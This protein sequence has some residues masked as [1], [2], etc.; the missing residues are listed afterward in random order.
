ME[1]SWIPR[2]TKSN[3]ILSKQE[4][5]RDIDTRLLDLV[6]KSSV[7]RKKRGLSNEERKLTPDNIFALQ[8][9]KRS[10]HDLRS[11]SELTGWSD[12]VI[13]KYTKE[14]PQVSL[15]NAQPPQNIPAVSESSANGSL[16]LPDYTPTSTGSLE[17]TQTTRVFSG[18]LQVTR[19]NPGFVSFRVPRNVTNPILNLTATGSTFEVQLLTTQQWAHF[20]PSRPPMKLWEARWADHDRFYQSP[21]VSSITTELKLPYVDVWCLV[22]QNPVGSTDENS[23][24]LDVSLTTTKQTNPR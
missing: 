13:S 5:S 1:R 4:R 22:F 23:I 19:A 9:L 17:V 2:G 14:I 20:Q 21:L 18:T 12:S 8:Q 16:G 10:G 11:M 24:R 3:S 7:A 6:K 15:P